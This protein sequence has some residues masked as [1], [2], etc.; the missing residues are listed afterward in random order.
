VHISSGLHVAQ[1][2]VLQ[3]ANGLK[4]VWDVLVLLNVSDD[5]CGFGAFGEVDQVCL[6]DD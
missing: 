2:I 6:F 4:G 1:Y 3:V 5:I